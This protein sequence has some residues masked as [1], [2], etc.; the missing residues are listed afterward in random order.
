MPEWFNEWAPRKLPCNSGDWV[1]LAY[2]QKGVWDGMEPRGKGGKLHTA[3]IKNVDVLSFSDCMVVLKQIGQKGHAFESGFVCVWTN[4]LLKLQYSFENMTPGWKQIRGI[5]LHHHWIPSMMRH[6]K[7]P[8]RTKS[9]LELHPFIPL[10]VG[11]KHISM[12]L[13]CS[14]RSIY[15]L[16]EKNIPPFYTQTQLYCFEKYLFITSN[17]FVKFTWLI[18]H[19]WSLPLIH[20]NH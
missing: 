12:S 11:L 3:D 7:E 10:R 15:S 17:F 2:L 13:L 20:Q 19:M 9:N 4:G 6:L 18:N 14:S 5:K 8:L 1:P 16:L